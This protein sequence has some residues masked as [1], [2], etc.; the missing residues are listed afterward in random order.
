MY[1]SHEELQTQAES[2]LKREGIEIYKHSGEGSSKCPK[3]GEYEIK[4][5]GKGDFIFKLPNCPQCATEYGQLLEKRIS[6]LKDQQNREILSRRYEKAGIGRRYMSAE[7]TAAPQAGEVQ[8]RLVDRFRN[9]LNALKRNTEPKSQIVI[10]G[11]GTGKTY[12]SSALV[13]NVIDSGLSAKIVK[14]T[15]ITRAIKDG[16]KTKGITEA[17]IIERLSGWDLLVIDELGIQFDSE[18]E[19]IYLSDIIDNRYQDMKPTVFLTNLDVNAL[20]QLLGERLAD[21]IRQTSEVTSL[22]YPSLRALD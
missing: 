8:Q 21:R 7:L 15:E 11:V 19:K 17:E 22:D 4:E 13:K 18:M 3:H 16:W 1:K 10:G 12:L 14:V 6:E 5:V 20:K 2:E 9:I